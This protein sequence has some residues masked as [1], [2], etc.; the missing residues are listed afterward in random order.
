MSSQILSYDIHLSC[1]SSAKYCPYAAYGAELHLDVRAFFR[2]KQLAPY[3]ETN[4][5]RHSVANDMLLHMWK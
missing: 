5:I 4:S 2:K 3:A 1:C